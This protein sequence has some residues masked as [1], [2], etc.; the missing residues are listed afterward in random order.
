M[1]F[2]S[3]STRSKEEV[4]EACGLAGLHL[5]QVDVELLGRA[6]V[7]RGVTQVESEAH[8]SHDAFGERGLVAAPS[9]TV[10]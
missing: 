7:G 2:N 8:G 6:Q 10:G 1:R 9:D 3:I 5:A 4:A